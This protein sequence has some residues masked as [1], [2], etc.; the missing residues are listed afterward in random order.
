MFYEDVIEGYN[1]SDLAWMENDDDRY[2][3][4]LNLKFDRMMY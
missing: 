3:D 1:D 2:L 4:A